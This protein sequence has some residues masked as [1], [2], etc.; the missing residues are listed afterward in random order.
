MLKLFAMAIVIVLAA[1]VPAKAQDFE[2]GLTAYDR[3]DYAV[4]LREWR[5]LAALGHADA[6]LQLG[7]MHFHGEGVP[8]DRTA[9]MALWL[10]AAGE[11][12]AEAEFTI[13]AVYAMGYGFAQDDAAARKWLARSAAKGNL[14][15]IGMLAYLDGRAPSAQVAG[16]M[17]SPAETR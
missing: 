10:K 13:G 15:A 1:S 17:K 6:Q 11:G 16:S 14:N 5:P 3:G 7:F 9:A 12:H 4:A 8:Q 2:A